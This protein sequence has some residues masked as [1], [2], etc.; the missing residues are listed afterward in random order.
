[1]LLPGPML[2]EGR[3]SGTSEAIKIIPTVIVQVILCSLYVILLL[4]RTRD[5]RAHTSSNECAGVCLRVVVHLFIY[6][7]G[8]T[9]HTSMASSWHRSEERRVGKECQ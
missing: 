9:P 6:L 2:L 1:M 5:D 7:H 8:T 4:S 3:A